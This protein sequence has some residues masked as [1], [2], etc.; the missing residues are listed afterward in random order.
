M[1][2]SRGAFK[3]AFGF[4]ATYAIVWGNWDRVSDYYN[5]R[6]V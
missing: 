3:I 1:G 6:C 2:L 5:E 4:T